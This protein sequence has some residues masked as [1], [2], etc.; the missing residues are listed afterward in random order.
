[1]TPTLEQQ[2]I[3]ILRDDGCTFTVGTVERLTELLDQRTVVFPAFSSSI[4]VDLPQGFLEHRRI[5]PLHY[6]DK[7]DAQP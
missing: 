7:K 6:T 5:D 4:E 1:M 2:I 3:D